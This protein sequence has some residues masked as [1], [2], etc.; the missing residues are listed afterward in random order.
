M[1]ASLRRSRRNW[2]S[3]E[4]GSNTLFLHWNSFGASKLKLQ[5]EDSSQ[6]LPISSICFWMKSEWQAPQNHGHSSPPWKLLS[7]ELVT[8]LGKH[9]LPFKSATWTT[10]LIYWNDFISVHVFC[11]NCHTSV[12]FG[13]IL[14]FREEVYCTKILEHIKP[15]YG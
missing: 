6:L 11:S 10:A 2:N 9:F 5:E 12:I 8:S 4:S 7:G 14:I 3:L 1:K 13:L 15:L